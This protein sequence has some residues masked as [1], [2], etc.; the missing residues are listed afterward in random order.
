[1]NAYAR[2]TDPDSSHNAAAAVDTKRLQLLVIQALNETKVPM[3]SID[4]A[5]HLGIHLVS[6]SPRMKPL[7]NLGQIICVGSLPALNSNGR[8]RNLRH[9]IIKEK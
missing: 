3:T 7:E 1:M 4:I 6:I 5:K 2:N 8:I 9:Y